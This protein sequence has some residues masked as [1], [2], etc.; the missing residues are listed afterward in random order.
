MLHSFAKMD[1]VV[2]LLVEVLVVEG[3]KK[4]LELLAAPL[5]LLLLLLGRDEL[6]SLKNLT[7]RKVC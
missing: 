7:F 5:S 6:R 3:L 1:Q 4:I 2:D